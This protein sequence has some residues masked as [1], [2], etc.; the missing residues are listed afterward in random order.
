MKKRWIPLIIAS[1]VAA[2]VIGLRFGAETELERQTDIQTAQQHLN[3]TIAVVNADT[4]VMVNGSLYNYSAAIINTLIGDFV[5]VSPAMAQTG[6]ANGTYAAIVTFPSNVS[7]RVL[8]FNAAGPERVELEFQINPNLTEQEYLETFIAITELQLAINTTLASTYVSSILQ[9]F[10][11][12]QDHAYGVLQNNLADLLAVEMITLGDFT[13]NLD[14]EDVPFVPIQPRELDTPFYMDHVR[15]FA[16]EVANWYLH[17]YAMASDQFI[18]MREGLIRLTD[19][20]PEQEDAWLFMLEMWA[21]ISIEYG[22]MLDMFFED[23]SAHEDDLHEWHLENLAWNEALERYQAQVEDWHHISNTWLLD[24]EDWHTEYQEFL[25]DVVNYLD[26]LL[27]H[28]DYL[29]RSLIYVLEDLTAWKELLEDYEFRMFAQY[30]SLKVFVGEHVYQ[31]ELAN[32]FFE[33]LE[34][35]HTELSNFHEIWEE[36]ADELD[37]RYTILS[38]LQIDLVG[39]NVELNT[40]LS[41][42]QSGVAGLPG[43]IPSPPGLP[44]PVPEFDPTPIFVVDEAAINWMVADLLFIAEQFYYPYFQGLSYDQITRL[45]THALDLNT[46]AY[47]L[48]NWRTDLQGE[49]DNIAGSW[50]EEMV[51][52]YEEIATFHESIQTTT[53]QVSEVHSGL[54]SLISRLQDYYIPD[55]LY[56]LNIQPVELDPLERPEE[57]SDIP[58]PIEFVPL[59]TVE[60][61]ETI[62]SPSEYNGAQIAGMF[63]VQFPLDRNA[64][65]EVSGLELPPEFADYN[66]PVMV[67]EHIMMFAYRPTSPLVTPPPRPDDFW[68]S[69]DFMHEQLLSFDVDAFLSY[70][71]HQQVDLSIQRHEVFIDSIRYDI[72]FLFEDN[73][74]LMHDVN[75]EYNLFLRNLR[76]DTFAAA[77]YEQDALQSTIATFVDM[78]ETTNENTLDRIGTFAH[79]MPESRGVVG[80][81]QSLVDFAVMPFDFVPLDIRDEVI[82]AQPESMLPTYTRFQIFTLWVVGGVLTVTMLSFLISYLKEKVARRKAD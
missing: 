74:W 71:I 25:R 10:H 16:A 46:Y 32:A 28:H 8:S 50:R 81:N 38:A 62:I 72:N 78:R 24:A 82:F 1:I 42:L 73:I 57:L 77:A 17:S 20:F 14:L 47:Q 26:T 5:L 44:S 4:G 75:L 40:F 69:L 53:G 41:R 12:A 31:I 27:A 45:R 2:F 9:Q 76:A 70:D 68:D 6:F 55:L 56:T 11:N 61:D 65:G 3:T 30:E 13:A 54:F 58:E 19:G 80:I 49:I 15:S 29:D 34:E 64:I 35:W 66:V 67:H 22:E 7:A 59:E 36:W 48:T 51:S 52:Y 79:M 18:W 43:N 33:D 21:D 63:D 39:A 60:W 23:V 37:E